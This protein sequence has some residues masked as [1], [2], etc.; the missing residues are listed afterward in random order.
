MPV[1]T[2]ILDSDEFI[3]GL[4]EEKEAS[5][6]LLSILE[7]FTVLIPEIIIEE[8]KDNLRPEPFLLSKFLDFIFGVETFRVVSNL[9]PEELVKDFIRQL[10]PADAL[11]AAYC[12]WL[13]A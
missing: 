2:L 10:K 9:P 4:K 12:K 11:I 1:S 5:A 6:K 13:G 3:F 8:V 7:N